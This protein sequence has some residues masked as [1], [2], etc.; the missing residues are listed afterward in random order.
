MPWAS[1]ASCNADGTPI[2][3][4]GVC[5]QTIEDTGALTKKRMETIDDET[6]DAAIDF[7][8]RQ[9]AAGTPFFCW[10]NATRMHLRTHVRAELP[11]Q[12]RAITTT[13]TTQRKQPAPWQAAITTT[14]TTQRKQP[15]P[16]QA[17]TDCAGFFTASDGNSETAL[18]DQPVPKRSCSM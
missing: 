17:M 13:K 16:W 12:N 6:S 10:F 8:K 7:V 5:K 1:L 15:A 3:P 9:V 11:P 18:L 2:D 14:K 4:L